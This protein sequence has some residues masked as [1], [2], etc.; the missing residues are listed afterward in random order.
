MVFC[1]SIMDIITALPLMHLDLDGSAGG[2]KLMVRKYLGLLTKLKI[3]ISYIPAYMRS[4]EVYA[5]L[6]N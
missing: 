1:H 6:K 2:G 3:V 4:C 5:S